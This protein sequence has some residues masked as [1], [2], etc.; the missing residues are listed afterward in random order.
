VLKYSRAI[1]RVIV[2]LKTDVSEIS[3]VSIIGVDVVNVKVEVKIALR[4][5]ASQSVSQSV[6]LGVD[7]HLGLMTTF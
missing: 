6:R 5:T 1:S 7:P 3:S 2:E 4:L